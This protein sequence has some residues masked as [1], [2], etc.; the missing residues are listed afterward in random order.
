MKYI[1]MDVDGVLNNENTKDCNP[2]GYTGV[3]MKLVHNLAKIVK[4]TNAKIILTS[5][6]KYGWSEIQSCCDDDI[7]YLLG[8]LKKCGL[9]IYNRTYDEKL[10]DCFYTDRG[11]GIR[12]F[13]ESCE[14][15]EGYVII[16]NHVF[17]DFDNEQKAHFIHTDSKKGLTEDDVQKAIEIL[18]D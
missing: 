8:K 4:S 10:E 18:L 16:D 6:W 17:A 15:V 14:D 7:I 3:S 9:K 11:V 13:L 1:F 2:S 5:D 12:H